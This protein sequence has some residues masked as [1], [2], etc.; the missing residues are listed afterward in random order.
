MI[1]AVNFQASSFQLLN[2]SCYESLK[3]NFFFK[4]CCCCSLCSNLLPLGFAAIQ[5]VVFAR[6]WTNNEG[7]SNSGT[8]A[9]DL[10]LC[11][12]LTPEKERYVVQ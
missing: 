5:L 10:L 12:I 9:I 7:S 2:D 6:C 4:N 3:P 8:Q 1:I 11:F